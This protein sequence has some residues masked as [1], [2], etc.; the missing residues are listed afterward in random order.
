MK[1]DGMAKYIAAEMCQAMN[2]HWGIGVNDFCYLSPKEI[3]ENLCACRKVG[4]N[5]LLNVGPSAEG[6]IPDYEAAAL[7]RVGQWVKIHAGAIYNG[8][9]SLLSNCLN[10]DSL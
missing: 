7:R 2:M 4:A 5:F 9:P 6:Q 3:I 10:K 8:K 1:R